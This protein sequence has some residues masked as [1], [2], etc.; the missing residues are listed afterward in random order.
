MKEMWRRIRGYE[1]LYVVSNLGRV[2][3]L[4]RE[5]TCSREGIQFSR[6]HEGRILK[7]R[8]IGKRNYIILWRSA[9]DHVQIRVDKLVATAWVDN[10]NNFSVVSHIDSDKLNDRADN[11]C[12]SEFESNHEITSTEE[13][14]RPVPID[15]YER[16]YEVS[17]TG[18]VRS[19]HQ[20][21]SHNSSNGSSYNADYI[22]KE[23][24]PFCV[25]KKSGLVKY[26][27][28]KRYRKG[29]YG[30]TDIYVFA[31]QLVRDAFPELYVKE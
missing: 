14:W 1:D 6:R 9:D 26:H 27:L 16:L 5:V 30:Q 17:N 4:P 31:E 23:I 22:A 18:R 13:E 21:I 11:L 10:P 3:A 29:Y 20:F 15:G 7:T 2:K 12:W 8:V 19:I 25:L 28:H 24:K